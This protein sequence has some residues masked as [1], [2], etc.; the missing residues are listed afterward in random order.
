MKKLLA[1]AV[2][3]SL[4]LYAVGCS[5]PAHTPKKDKPAVEKKEKAEPKAEAKTEAKEEKK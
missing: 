3:L 4:G 1:F 5:R 2:V